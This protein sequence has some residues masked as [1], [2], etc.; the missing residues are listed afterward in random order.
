MP[1]DLSRAAGLLLT[2]QR[3]GVAE[4]PRYYIGILKPLK[5]HAVEICQS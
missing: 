4:R 3:K 1:G 5:F 2:A